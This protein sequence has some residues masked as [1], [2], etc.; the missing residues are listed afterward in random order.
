MPVNR[1]PS[2]SSSRSRWRSGREPE[3]RRLGRSRCTERAVFPSRPSNKSR[4]RRPPPSGAPSATR[5]CCGSASATALRWQIAST[6]LTTSVSR[7]A[8]GLARTGH[9]ARSGYAR[10]ASLSR[11]AASAR[12]PIRPPRQRSRRPS[13]VAARAAQ[14]LRLDARS[15]S[16]R[17]AL[18]PPPDAGAGDS[19]GRPRPAARRQTGQL[20]GQRSRHSRRRSSRRECAYVRKAQA[21]RLRALA[22]GVRNPPSRSATPPSGQGRRRI[23]RG[24]RASRRRHRSRGGL[25]PIV[26]CPS[27]PRRRSG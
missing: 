1:S 18:A 25:P 7:T 16:P 14:A 17:S 9:G 6:V 2:S 11:P 10:S 3:D 19:S 15:R 4:L 8:P 24:S 12:T 23:A 5:A 13:G 27:R 21:L 22:C 26:R 20:T